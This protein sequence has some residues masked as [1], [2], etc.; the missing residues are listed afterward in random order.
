MTLADLDTLDELLAKA[1]KTARTFHEREELL[2]EIANASIQALPELLKLARE[3]ARLT[4]EKGY[5]CILHRCAAHYAVTQQN[6]NEYTGAECGGCIAAERDALRNEN[7]VLL[8]KLN[9]A[10]IG[11]RLENDALRARYEK[12]ERAGATVV[13]GFAEGA[14]VRNMLDDSNPRWA[15]KLLP[16]LQALAALEETK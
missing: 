13:R 8:D 11:I 14:F 16:Y 5:T 10:E 3:H 4:D 15:I 2:F 9:E 7:L 12:L 1:A 6:A